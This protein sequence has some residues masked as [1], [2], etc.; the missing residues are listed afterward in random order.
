MNDFGKKTTRTKHDIQF[1]QLCSLYLTL[2]VG[3]GVASKRPDNV[4][5]AAVLISMVLSG[6]TTVFIALA[7][8]H[9]V[10]FAT[11]LFMRLS[12]ALPFVASLAMVVN[13]THFVFIRKKDVFAFAGGGSIVF[14]LF[15]TYI[16]AVISGAPIFTV[17]FLS[18]TAPIWSLILGRLFLNEEVT[19]RKLWSLV[20]MMIGIT[21]LSALWTT[22]FVLSIGEGLALGNGLLFSFYLVLVKKM[23]RYEPLTLTTVFFAFAMVPLIALVL[24]VIPAPKWEGMLFNL[25]GIQWLLMLGLAFLGTALPF[26]LLNTGLRHTQAS[27]AGFL[28]LATPVVATA[29]SVIALA[30]PVEFNQVLGGILIV[31]SIAN[32][33][34]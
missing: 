32:L 34:H 11:Q 4:A 3:R 24:I 31:L 23:E 6:S 15:S 20:G 28:N 7:N 8:V 27:I 12:L 25:N 29:L 9:G 1:A 21:L 30:Q 10:N 17:V 16:A 26:V 14:T 2:R 19:G 33:H 22:H 13:G 18:N 5:F